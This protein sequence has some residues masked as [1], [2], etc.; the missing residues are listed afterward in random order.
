MLDSIQNNKNLDINIDNSH[1][2]SEEI[3]LSEL[4]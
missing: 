2:F 1:S 3:D 4:N